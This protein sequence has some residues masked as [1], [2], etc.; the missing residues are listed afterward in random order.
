MMAVVLGGARLGGALRVRSF[1][2]LWLGQAVSRLGDSVY[3]IALAWFVLEKTGSATAMGVVLFCS[4]TPMVF[5]LLLGGVAVDRFPRIRLLLGSDLARGVT[6][7]TMAALAFGHHLEIW[8]VYVASVLFGFVDAFFFPAYTAAVPDVAP[9]EYLPSANALTNISQSLAGIAGP[10]V[11]AVI[12]GTGGTAV[13]FALDAGSFAVS[14]VCLLPLLHLSALR[15]AQARTSGGLQ[16]L[17]EGIATVFGSPW[18]WITITI[19]ALGNVTASGP[20]SVALPFL[21]KRTLHTGVGTLGLLYSCA[22]VGSIAVA[23]GLGHR[24]RLPHRGLLAYGAFLVSGLALIAMGFPILVIGAAAAM[25]IS[26]GAIAAFGL[27]WTNALQELVPRDRLGRVSS[28]DALGSFVL[29]PVGYGITGWY[30]DL[31]GPPMVFL[32]G[33]GLTAALA[34]VGLLHPAI[35]HL[36]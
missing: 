36:D 13:A 14:V 28:I 31:A 11:G 29:L 33:G 3:R 22:A 25:V 35:R 9:A 4:F 23:A 1:A 20:I 2:L 5:F 34:V 8:H 6:T 12:V 32:V 26:G 7:A 16:D 21:V 18:L 24:S 17:R 27:A 10:A 15:R 30:T 19:F